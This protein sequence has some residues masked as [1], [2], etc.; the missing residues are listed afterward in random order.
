MPLVVEQHES[1]L[2]SLTHYYQQHGYLMCDPD[3]TFFLDQSGDQLLLFPLSITQSGL[4]IYR[5]VAF[6]N[7]SHDN[8]QSLLTNW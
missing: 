7:P 2:F 4:D 5:E 3:V 8:L 6:I 1:Y